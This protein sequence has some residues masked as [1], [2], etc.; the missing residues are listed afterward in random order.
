MWVTGFSQT[1]CITF[2]RW[3]ARIATLQAVVHSI[4][5]TFYYFW[6]GGSAAYYTEASKAFYW[7]GIIATLALFL[8]ASVSVLP[9]RIY[10][11]ESF[12]ITHILL[13]ILALV[14]TWYHIHL[15]FYERWGYKT[16]LYICFAFWL[17]DRFMRFARVMFYNWVGGRTEASAELLHGGEIIRLTVSP[18]RS[19]HYQPGQYTF[20]YFPGIGRVWESHPFSVCGWSSPTEDATP[21]TS[22][23][24]V[25]RDGLSEKISESEIKSTPNDSPQQA[26]QST[27]YH[28]S[29]GIITFLIRPAKGV[30]RALQNYLASRSPGPHSIEVLTEGPYGHTANLEHFKHILCIGG[31]IGITALLPYVQDFTFRNQGQGAQGQNG[32]D[33]H[34]MTL[35]WTANE[36][37]LVSAVREMIPE[38]TV[39]NAL[40]VCI[41]V[42]NGEEDRMNLREII[43]G[44][45][46]KVE[47]GGRLAVVV[48]GPPGMADEIRRNVVDCVGENGV[49]INMFEESFTW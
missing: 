16:W 25:E 24:E 41:K 47:K 36:Q 8:G 45:V 1:T 22:R 32:I 23:C 9:L 39:S 12:L 10:F 31:G 46:E 28:N 3:A 44:E 21:S 33:K 5:Y 18:G 20:L 27:N 2:H 7:W 42:T 29:H 40:E 19:W 17:F 14:A 34:S 6:E 15:E 49:L 11:Y 4:I 48:C 37:E 35:A 38:T 30:T 13:A 26:P 43:K